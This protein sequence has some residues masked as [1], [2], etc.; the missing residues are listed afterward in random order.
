M[1]K[2]ILSF[3]ALILFMFLVS[4]ESKEKKKI[5]Y[6]YPKH[7]GIPRGEMLVKVKKPIYIDHEEHGKE[8]IEEG[9]HGED[10]ERHD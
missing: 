1:K 6:Y 9:W 8:I 3:L 7:N 10:I 5:N 2:L 4:C